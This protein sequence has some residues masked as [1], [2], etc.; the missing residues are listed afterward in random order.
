[1]RNG[2]I[3]WKLYSMVSLLFDLSVWNFW[4]KHTNLKINKVN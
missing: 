2:Q 3:T 4:I 1:M